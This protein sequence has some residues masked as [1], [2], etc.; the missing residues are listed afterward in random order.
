MAVFI[1][2]HLI[3]SHSSLKSFLYL[4]ESIGE[5]LCG[6]CCQLRVV[7]WIF[8]RDLN[9]VV[10]SVLLKPEQLAIADFVDTISSLLNTC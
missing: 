7:P 5:N 9:L 3:Y 1:E 8:K 4:A 2:S 6:Q 10:L